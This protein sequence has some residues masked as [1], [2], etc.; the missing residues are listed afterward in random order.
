M[1]ESVCGCLGALA[2]KS[3]VFVCVFVLSILCPVCVEVPDRVW[4]CFVLGCRNFVL[5]RAQMCSKK[6]ECLRTRAKVRWKADANVIA[7]R[8]KNYSRFAKVM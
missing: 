8:W 5:G 1:W 2:G 6:K 7:K 3:F 4:V